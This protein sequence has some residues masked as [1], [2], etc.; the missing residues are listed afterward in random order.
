MLNIKYKG[1]KYFVPNH[2]RVGSRI[3]YLK[4]IPDTSPEIRPARY[5]FSRFV[6][7]GCRFYLWGVNNPQVSTTRPHA[8]ARSALIRLAGRSATS[9]L[10]KRSEQ[11]P[12]SSW[13]SGV[14]LWKRWHFSSTSLPVWPNSLTQCFR[15]SGRGVT[16]DECAEA[17]ECA[18]YPLLLAHRQAQ[19]T[20]RQRCV[21]YPF[22]PS[23]SPFMFKAA[24]KCPWVHRVRFSTLT[25]DIGTHC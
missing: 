17:H 14:H 18:S 9:T 7:W 5:M 11:A 10:H 2:L 15:S 8:L 13:C 3:W 24:S 16:R 19:P 25:I 21:Y 20:C 22:V 12:R 6:S 1:K 23:S 4:A